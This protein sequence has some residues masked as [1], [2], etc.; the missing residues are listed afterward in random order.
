MAF[1]EEYV[2][3]YANRL[4]VDNQ[5]MLTV[6]EA[7]ASEIE[8]A[9]NESEQAFADQFL[10]ISGIQGI[11]R[12]EKMLDIKPDVLEQ[13]VE[14][15]R[16]WAQ[17]T[18]ALTPPFTHAYLHQRLTTLFGKDNFTLMIIPSEYRIVIDITAEISTDLYEQIMRELK[19]TIPA[20]MILEYTEALPYTHAYLE[21]FTH[22]YLEQFTHEELS[23]FA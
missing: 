21:Q 15:R 20:N 13:S 7:Q 10:N 17:I 5:T 23:K 11:E 19:T 3:R 2:K 12:Y 9:D 4:Y 8:K 22:A 6:Y 16:K 14:D 18:M 1:D